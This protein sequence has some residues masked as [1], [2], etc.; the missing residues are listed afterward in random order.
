MRFIWATR[1]I[2]IAPMKALVQEKMRDWKTKLG[3][4]GVDCLEMTG[5]NEFYNNKSI[6]DADL[7][8]TTP[9]VYVTIVLLPTS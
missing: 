9:E 7:I 4:L 5:D 1:Q 6:H 8:L 3:S 2:Y